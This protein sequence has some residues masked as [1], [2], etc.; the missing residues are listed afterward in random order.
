MATL[1]ASTQLQ[2][3]QTNDI[4]YGREEHVTKLRT[5]QKQVLIETKQSKL[6]VVKGSS[7]TGKSALVRHV[8]TG[9]NTNGD[10]D[11]VDYLVGCG[12]YD[13]GNEEGG[14]SSSM[15]YSAI[16]EAAQEITN[17]AI[18]R[19]TL[20]ASAKKASATTKT[21]TITTSQS[22]FTMDDLQSRLAQSTKLHE[23][24]RLASYVPSLKKKLFAHKPIQPQDSAPP[25]NVDHPQ[26][27]HQHHHQHPHFQ[28]RYED[29]HDDDGHE[30]STDMSDDSLELSS[31]ANSDRS[32]SFVLDKN[33]TER[34]KQEL[35]ELLRVLQTPVVFILDDLQWADPL[36]MEL[37][38]ALL[39]PDDCP[40]PPVCLYIGTQRT[41]DV[42]TM[43]TGTS[44][45]ES[46]VLSI[47]QSLIHETIFLEAID[48]AHIQEW[49]LANFGCTDSPQYQSD[50]PAFHELQALTDLVYEKTRGN[51]FYVSMFVNTMRS[52]GHIWYDTPTSSWK[53]DLEQLHNATNNNDSV[54]EFLMN[55][56][57]NLPASTKKVLCIASSFGNRFEVGVVQN[58]LQH[59]R[60]VEHTDHT[61]CPFATVVSVLQLAVEQGVVEK[62]SDRRYRF[63]HDRI[64]QAC[65]NL[66]ID[67]D[68]DKD[69]DRHD[70]NPATT[71]DN[72]HLTIGRLLW[73]KLKQKEAQILPEA[74]AEENNARLQQTRAEAKAA[75][76]HLLA[77]H[78][79]TLLLLTTEQ[80][81]LAR[82]QLNSNKERVELAQLNLQAAKATRKRSA[83]LAACNFCMAG[84]SLMDDAAG[85]ESSPWTGSYD[86]MLALQTTKARMNF[87]IGDRCETRQSVDEILQHA[88]S[89][90]D[91]VPA[92]IVKMESY[93]SEGF[94]NEAIQE[95][96]HVLEQAGVKLPTAPSFPYLIGE[97]IATKRLLRGR[98][99]ED[100]LN[101]PDL[102]CHSSR[103][104]LEVMGLVG[105]YAYG[106]S[107]PRVVLL[108]GLREMRIM[109]RQGLSRYSA[110]ALSTYGILAGQMGNFADA[111]RFGELSVK[112]MDRFKHKRLNSRTMLANHFFLHHLRKPI[113][114]SI[115]PLL[116]SY[117]DGMEVGDVRFA[118]LSFFAY[119][120][121]YSLCG[122][123][124][125]PVLQD[126]RG[127]REELRSYGQDLVCQATS[128]VYQTMLNLVGRSPDPLR[129][130]GDAMDEDQMLKEAKDTDNKLL[131]QSI[132]LQKALLAI[133]FNDF[134]G[135]GN[136]ASEIWDDMQIKMGNC[137][138]MTA[139]TY[140]VLALSA[141]GMARPRCQDGLCIRSKRTF[142]R[143]GKAFTKKLEYWV[144]HGEPNALHMLLILKAEQAFVSKNR[145]EDV[146]DAYDKA[147]AVA[148]RSGFLQ[149]AA[150]ANERAGIYFLEKED[151]DTFSAETYIVR[152]H[153]LYSDWGAQAKLDQM[154][155]RYPFLRKS[156]DLHI[157]HSTSRFG[158]TR[159]STSLPKH[160]NSSSTSALDQDDIIESIHE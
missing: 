92:Y 5:I 21:T 150:L 114:Q 57:R 100:I 93:S 18:R 149:N 136:A 94:L 87:V 129:L 153:Q 147:I 125:G 141:L 116:Q 77:M 20:A 138:F 62:R 39:Q 134:I 68:K 88:T 4:L 37:L 124:L 58:V 156:Q 12:K 119:I 36:S 34:L 128:T 65:Y 104:I 99:D 83:F 25:G 61:T 16:M 135:A 6:V 146:K 91:K 13:E 107:K 27:Q 31:S 76:D 51:P 142:R 90:E 33:E 54:V 96:F 10:D 29:H 132:Y 50:Q 140:F 64:H 152:A 133:Y 43:N 130:T 17:K 71:N 86:L 84:L 97:V 159:F 117:N 23:S 151:P 56:L 70:D 122:L 154:L 158:R 155:Q 45:N 30:Y 49:L 14:G 66:A 1:S 55:K 113:H 22:A 48:T 72:I 102:C 98:T 15:P 75:G 110:D 123:Q 106:A 19:A 79:T 103:S 26:E 24:C 47:D 9:D 105:G 40:D 38:Q 8:F 137:N 126:T 144:K 69:K 85:D 121:C 145:T 42:V 2:Q 89:F 157:H 59:M 3:Q 108:M 7:G 148:Q 115:E 53:Y 109:L 35:M 63:A 101:L 41:D 139:A 143:H 120:C 111:H 78:K 82:T 52:E 73:T 118:S 28:Y 80:M 112:L 60:K 127:F 95:G 67:K 32:G 131:A 160:R 44:H 74:T 11:A 81:N 46:D